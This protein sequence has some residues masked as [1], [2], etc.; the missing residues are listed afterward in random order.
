MLEKEGAEG[1]VSDGIERTEL[2]LFAEG[3]NGFGIFLLL[4]TREAEI[5]VGVLVIGI[6]V[7]LLLEGGG[8]V[9]EPA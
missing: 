4:L 3:G 7:D 8:R 2:D 9:G 1:G 5:V 6:D